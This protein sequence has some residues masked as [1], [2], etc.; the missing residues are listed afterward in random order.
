MPSG[1][2][3]VRLGLAVRRSESSHKTPPPSPPEMSTRELKLSRRQL[4]MS[5]KELKSSRM[6]LKLSR[7]ELKTRRRELENK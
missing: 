1:F 2:A 6:E 5:G 3:C 7:R 4:R